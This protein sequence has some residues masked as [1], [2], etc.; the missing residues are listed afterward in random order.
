M[1]NIPDLDSVNSAAEAAEIFAK[2]L[3]ERLRAKGLSRDEVIQLTKINY[4]FV[5]ALLAGQFSELPGDVFG[6]GFV[7]NICK[8]LGT[9][10]DDLLAWFNRGCGEGLVAEVPAPGTKVMNAKK[11][12]R[13][14]FEGTGRKKGYRSFI[15]F[16]GGIILT[17]LVSLTVVYLVRYYSEPKDNSTAAD[18]ALNDENGNESATSSAI[19]EAK[20]EKVAGEVG[21]GESAPTQPAQPVEVTQTQAISTPG[22][23]VE[24]VSSANG[25]V[26]TSTASVPAGTAGAGNG[27][28]LLEI[29]VREPVKIRKKIGDEIPTVTEFSPQTYSYKVEGKAELLI[30]DA[31]AVRIRFAGRDLG[32]LGAKGRVR[33]LVFVSEKQEK[34]LQ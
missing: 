12:A 7:K 29:E 18:L 15:V 3:T 24:T 33:R 25:E 9:G 10:N 31:G 5:D 32:D 21:V 20:P 30:Y 6:R 17:L 13:F 14:F 22:K 23:Q 19:S 28:D 34:K 26:L 16:A 11:D 8:L 1:Q 27:N 4:K 2:L